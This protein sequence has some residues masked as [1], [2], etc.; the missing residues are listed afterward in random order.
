MEIIFDYLLKALNTLLGLL[1]QE[2][3]VVDKENNFFENIISM[4]KGLDGYEV[5]TPS[6]VID[7]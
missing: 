3:I 1:G 4:I 6:N 7:M 2:E 5:E